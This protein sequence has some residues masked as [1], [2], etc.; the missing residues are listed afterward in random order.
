MRTQLE[1]HS[2]QKIVTRQEEE[3]ERRRQELL[4]AQARIRELEAALQSVCDY[5]EVCS[6]SPASEVLHHKSSQ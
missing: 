6:H 3:L 2:L 1:G 5:S 4:R